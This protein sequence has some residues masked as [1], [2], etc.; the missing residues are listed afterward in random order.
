MFKNAK[1]LQKATSNRRK[2]WHYDN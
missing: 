1:S 2:I